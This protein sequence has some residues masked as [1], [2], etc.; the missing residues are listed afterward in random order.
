MFKFILISITGITFG[1]SLNAMENNKNGSPIK[2]KQ[3][4]F[5]RCMAAE[6]RKQANSVAKFAD[7]INNNSTIS[8]AEKA[9]YLGGLKE[10]FKSKI[11]KADSYA[12]GFDA[13]RQETN[14]KKD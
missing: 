13:R 5:N 6:W 10:D 1:L 3:N 2:D 11:N 8:A 4:A 14:D 7:K 9:L 12:A